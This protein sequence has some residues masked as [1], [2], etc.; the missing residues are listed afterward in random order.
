MRSRIFGRLH[1][2]VPWLHGSVDSTCAMAARVTWAPTR[3]KAA[4]VS[5]AS[6][7]AM[8]ARVACL[9]Y[10]PCPKAG[11]V[12]SFLLHGNLKLGASSLNDLN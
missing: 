9:L 10:L 5:G 4:R 2:P 1:H 12:D 8:A 6:T 7:R 11:Q 3:A